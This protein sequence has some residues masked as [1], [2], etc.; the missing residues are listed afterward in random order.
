MGLHKMRI[1][2]VSIFF[3]LVCF[4]IQGQQ[5]YILLHRGNSTFE[6][7][8]T[9]SLL[10]NDTST[11]S[12]NPGELLVFKLMSEDTIQ[13]KASLVKKK[14]TL[15]FSRK[16]CD[17]PMLYLTS[18]TDSLS[19]LELKGESC[20]IRQLEKNFAAEKF[21]SLITNNQVKVKTASVSG[22]SVINTPEIDFMGL[23]NSVINPEPQI[24]INETELD[25]IKLLA[26]EAAMLREKLREQERKTREQ[27]QEY[28]DL[29]KTIDRLDQN[30]TPMV[31]IHMEEG[32]LDN[33][34]LMRYNIRAT[35]TYDVEP[36]ESLKAELIHYPS[37]AYQLDKSAAAS[38]TAFAMKKSIDSYLIEYF[39]P[40]GTV[41]I[42]VIGSA[43]GAPINRALSYSGEYGEIKEEDYFI[44]EDYFLQLAKTYAMDSSFIEDT[45]N[46]PINKSTGALEGVTPQPKPTPMG[47]AQQISLSIE[48]SSYKT[49]EDLAFL[50][51]RGIQFYIDGEITSLSNTRNEYLFQVK[52]EDGI[53]GIFRKVVIEL[54]IE[55]V[56]RDK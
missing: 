39:E 12:I 32:G 7:N 15:N 17:F 22:D 23:L 11:L 53:G 55:D 21:N 10:V 2:I 46:L 5:E 31:G 30:V 56:L 4:P 33:R 26:L 44:T 49:N 38:A 24:L 35:Y 20:S 52:I 1:V 13:I 47:A 6:P 19:F 28:F 25:S 40:G 54:L 37:G 45:N 51:A 48:G 36:T 43:D 16:S 8:T 50:R 34:G 14:R 9:V 18:D 42:R 41:K 29:M 3:I 27:F